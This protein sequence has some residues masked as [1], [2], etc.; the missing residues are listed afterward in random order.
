MFVAYF[1]HKSNII[2]ILNN[3]FAIIKCIQP[4]VHADV[5]SIALFQKH[6]FVLSQIQIYQT[7]VHFQTQYAALTPKGNIG[8]EDDN[9]SIVAHNIIYVL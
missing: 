6:N 2:I 5:H 7:N 9:Y 4:A 3:Y 8:I 1:I